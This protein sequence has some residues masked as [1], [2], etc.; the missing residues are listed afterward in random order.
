MAVA[1]AVNPLPDAAAVMVHAPAAPGA[2]NTPEFV[3]LP[4]DAD[5]VTG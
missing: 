1:V 4:H 5:Q 3:M 2:V